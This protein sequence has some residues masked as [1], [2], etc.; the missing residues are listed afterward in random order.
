LLLL[1]LW[2][3]GA[4]VAGAL[5]GFLGSGFVVRKSTKALIRKEAPHV[6]V[7]PF[8]VVG[9]AIGGWL[10]MFAL[11]GGLGFGTGEGAGNGPAAGVQPSASLSNENRAANLPA[12]PQVP[13]PAPLTLRIRLLGGPRVQGE[14]FYQLDDAP[15]PMTLEELEKSIDKR[16]EHGLKGIEILIYQNSVARNHPAVHNLEDWAGQQGLSVTIPPTTGNLP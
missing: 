11:G 10:V 5:F 15:E 14:R 3:L 1:A 6:I 7:F 4:V 13:A 12:K 9:G 2:K 16:K 8:R